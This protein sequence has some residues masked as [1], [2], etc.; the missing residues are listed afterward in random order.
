M[1]KISKFHIHGT[2]SAKSER[3][4]TM[5]LVKI[6]LL[7][8]I[9]YIIFLIEFPLPFFP[10]FLEIDFSD[11]VAILGGIILGPMA[12][13]IIQFIKNLLRL[14]LMNSGT[15]GI[16]ELANLLVGIAYVLPFCL[17]FR[18]NNLK[19]FI[20]GSIVAIIIMTVTAGLVNYF[21]NI[22]VYLGSTPHAEK[23]NMIYSFYVPF[24]LI[25]GV[26]VTIVSYVAVKAFKQVINK[27]Q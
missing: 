4:N 11:T 25:K 27:L 14:L 9:A 7:S 21:I 18:R 22:P 2:N 24:N 8:A 3:F 26:I 15:G 5:Y 12:A 1:E 6:A 13:V 10:P 17:I 20:I 16:G 19:R 23:M